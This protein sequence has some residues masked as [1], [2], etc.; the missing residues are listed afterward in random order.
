[1]HFRQTFQLTRSFAPSH[2]GG[3]LLHIGKRFTHC[4]EAPVAA[5]PLQIRLCRPWETALVVVARKL[6]LPNEHREC[7]LEELIHSGLESRQDL[8]GFQDP[9]SLKFPHARLVIDRDDSQFGIERPNGPGAGV[10]VVLDFLAQ[11]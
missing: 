9:I 5:G 7:L 10:Q 8:G 1:M 11:F 6:E 3:E 4:G 2:Q